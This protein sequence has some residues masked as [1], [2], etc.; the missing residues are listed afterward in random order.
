MSVFP[1]NVR[2]MRCPICVQPYCTQHLAPM[3]TCEWTVNLREDNESPNCTFLSHAQ[4]YKLIVLCLSDQLNLT[5][6]LTGCSVILCLSTFHITSNKAVGLN[7]RL[8]K[9]NYEKGRHSPSNLVSV[10][11]ICLRSFRRNTTAT[12]VCI[13]FPNM[14]TIFQISLKPLYCRHRSTSLS[15][16]HIIPTH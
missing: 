11:R 7:S 5:W 12:A 2:I 4:K 9:R 16:G 8:I 6:N 1:P 14:F 13:C 15:N 3:H 10:L